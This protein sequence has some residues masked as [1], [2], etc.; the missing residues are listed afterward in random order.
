MWSEEAVNPWSVALYNRWYSD[1]KC[2]EGIYSINTF[3]VAINKNWGKGYR[4]FIAIDNLFD[5]ENVNINAYGRL[6]HAG[7]EMTF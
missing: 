7:V 1:Y 2:N 5:K 3:N 6:W 4:A